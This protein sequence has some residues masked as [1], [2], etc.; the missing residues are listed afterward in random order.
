MYYEE[1]SGVTNFVAGVV[2]GAI[3]GAGIA[4]LTTPQS[5]KSMRTRLVRIGRGGRSDPN[6]GEME[7]NEIMTAL[8]R[9][10]RRVRR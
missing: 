9:R 7:H 6:D 1:E 5:G 10:H 8:K 4:L 2:V 3:L